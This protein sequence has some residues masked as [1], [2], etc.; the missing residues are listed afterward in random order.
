MDQ[1]YSTNIHTHI[2]YKASKIG[3]TFATVTLRC[4]YV[5]YNNELQNDITGVLN[6]RALCTWTFWK[7]SRSQILSLLKMPLFI[8]ASFLL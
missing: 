2:Q 4:S 7:M 3:S 5:Y 6:V 1:Y 8:S